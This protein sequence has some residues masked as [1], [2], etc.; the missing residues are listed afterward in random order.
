MPEY[1]VKVKLTATV[2]VR[3]ADEMV[4][5]RVATSLLLSLTADD[6]RILDGD[7]AASRGN[8]TV[9]EATFS[10]EGRP[11][12]VAIGAKRAKRSAIKRR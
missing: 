8:A 5:R 10:V 4:A 3:A 2:R 9:I 6:I 7:D 11:M 12:I 1:G